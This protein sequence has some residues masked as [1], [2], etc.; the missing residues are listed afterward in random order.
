MYTSIKLYLNTNKRPSTVS[1][2][3]CR[4]KWYIIQT[5]Q[6]TTNQRS[7]ASGG[8]SFVF[9]LV[10]NSSI[11]FKLCQWK[12]HCLLNSIHNDFCS[13]GYHFFVN[14]NLVHVL[15]LMEWKRL[16]QGREAKSQQPPSLHFT[17]IYVNWSTTHGGLQTSF[18]LVYKR[19]F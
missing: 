15:C 14:R 9:K 10:V 13:T 4:T 1:Y 17:L 5:C 2:I 19:T 18:A 7:R 12:A 11:A 16:L 6:V 3:A 8:H